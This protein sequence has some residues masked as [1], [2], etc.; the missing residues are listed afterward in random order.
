MDEKKI[1]IY[2]CRFTT[3]MMDKLNDKINRINSKK[4]KENFY[5]I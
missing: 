2:D 4:R 5:N 3:S 1:P